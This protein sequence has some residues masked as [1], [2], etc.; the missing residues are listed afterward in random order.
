MFELPEYLTLAAQIN[1]TLAG[2]AVREGSLGNSP[3]KFVWYNRTHEEFSRLTPGSTVGP[4]RVKGR[5]LLIP[6][7]PDF[8][9]LLGE[10]GGRILYHE[11]GSSLPKKYH[12]FLRFEDDSLFTVTTQMWG[13]M[14]LYEKGKE[15]EGKYVKDMRVT[16]VEEGFTF[17]YFQALLRSPEAE[18]KTAKGILTQDQLVPGLGN[19]IAQDILFRARLHPR[20]R[21]D[22]LTPEQEGV[23]FDAILQTV[24]EITKAGGR[25]DETDLFGN[26]GGYVRIMDRNARGNP[27]P[28]CGATVEKIQYLGGACYLC[29]TCQA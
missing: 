14:E 15:L 4:A 5:F 26:P 2:K 7:D 29:P 22:D 1:E 8:V 17:D 13:A 20:R 6:L 16:P 10:C 24:R 23:L 18:K 12:L 28:E 9:L 25:S 27:C 3:H 21:L 19:S 11:P